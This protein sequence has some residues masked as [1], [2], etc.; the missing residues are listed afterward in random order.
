MLDCPL[1]Q[2]APISHALSSTFL[3]LCDLEMFKG[4]QAHEDHQHAGRYLY[5][6]SL[7]Q[8][9]YLLSLFATIVK[10]LIKKGVK[11]VLI[12]SKNTVFPS[13]M[14]VLTKRI[15]LIFVFGIYSNQIKT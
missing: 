10:P 15:V 9:M 7:C 14:L 13:Q 6:T 8:N 5:V 2:I 11:R 1:R 12:K 3:N 4:Y